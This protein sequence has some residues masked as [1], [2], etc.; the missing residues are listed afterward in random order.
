MGVIEEKLKLL[1]TNPGVYIM[2]NG[3]G[4]VIYVGK[5][6]NLKNRVRQYFHDSVKTQKVMAMVKILPTFPTLLLQLKLTLYR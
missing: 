4:K 1:P 5:A 2:L 3:E 6:K